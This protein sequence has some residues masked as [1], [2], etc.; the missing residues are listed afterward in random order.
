[1]TVIWSAS[2]KPDDRYRLALG[3]QLTFVGSFAQ[4]REAVEN[5]VAERL[6]VIDPSVLIAHALEVAEHYRVARPTLGVILIRQHLDLAQLN[7]AMRSG[8][9]EVIAGDDAAN[10]LAATER[11][12]EVSKTLEAADAGVQ[13]QK[14]GRLSVVF[15]AKGGCGKTTLSTNLA[16]QLALDHSKSVCLVDLDLQFGDVAVAL[17][18]PPQPNLSDA[19]RMRANLDDLAVSSLLLQPKK[20]LSVLLAPAEPAAADLIDAALVQK[21]LT[22]LQGRFDHV[23]VDSPPAFTEVIMQAF[24]MADDLLLL[25]T[26]D[27]PSVKNLKLT[28]ET[29][30]ALGLPRTKWQVIVNRASAKAGLTVD[31]VEASIGLPVAGVIPESDIVPSLINR[32]QTVVSGSPNHAVALAIAKVAERISPNQNPAVSQIRPNLLQRLRL[33]RQ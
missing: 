18:L 4:L 12:L 17:Q 6:V 20:N 1:M 28:I 30:D 15:S 22:N 5:D 31:T 33:V 13:K 11:S 32:G 7:L 23:I 8:V 24:D 27:L 14:L 3:A 2:R 26:L 16:E 21:I 10:L 25:S 19:V 9:R 29:L